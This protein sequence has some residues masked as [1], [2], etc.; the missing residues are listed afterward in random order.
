MKRLALLYIFVTAFSVSC[1]CCN[2]SQMGNRGSTGSRD[3]GATTRSEGTAYAE[4]EGTYAGS[5]PCF[6]G[7]TTMII[8]LGDNHYLLKRI[9]SIKNENKGF[10]LRGE[11]SR[12]TDGGKI[13]LHGDAAPTLYLVGKDILIPLDEDGQP[14][15][16][17]GTLFC[18]R[19][20]AR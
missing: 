9:Y 14:L 12:S 10:E 16:S 6:S 15:I 11:Y 3:Y 2:P 1:V 8:T 19:K 4:W 20:V 17:S 7:V 5:P 18:L 13:H